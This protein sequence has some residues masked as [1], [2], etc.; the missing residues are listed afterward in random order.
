MIEFRLFFREKKNVVA[1]KTTATAGAQSHGIGHK[2]GV[3]G[4]LFLLAVTSV[5]R[6]LVG[7]LLTENW[8]W[9]P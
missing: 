8:A 7:G 9:Q 6:S 1:V 2:V 4:L 5:A 3:E